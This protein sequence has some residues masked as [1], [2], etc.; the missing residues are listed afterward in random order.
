MTDASTPDSPT[1]AP[2]AYRF[3]FRL[4]INADD[5]GLSR[6]VNRGMM[7]LAD[8]GVVTS[9]S[10]LPHGPAF[11]ADAAELQ[12]RPDVST[13]LH[14]SLGPAGGMDSSG[15]IL[16]AL[17]ARDVSRLTAIFEDQLDALEQAI[18]RSITHVDSHL[19][20]HA[21]P[22]LRTALQGICDARN[23]PLRLPH[24]EVAAPSVKARMLRALF[25]GSDPDVAFFGIDLMG[26]IDRDRVEQT[27]EHIRQKGFTRAVW[28]V[29][30]GHVSDDHPDW[31]D[32]RSKR[33]QEFSAL[34]D[35]APWLQTAAHVVN[36]T[37][38]SD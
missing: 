3:P 29:H 21:V 10:A 13:G 15:H 38:L 12:R 16:P 30:P 22:A 25:S 17:K 33:E 24:E 11:A 31:D 23:L 9:V 28:M 4:C 35:L 19:H 36:R 26:R 34:R 27:F 37:A 18:G 32:Y 20:V 1:E 7:E 2:A 14:A 8:L 5:F 6:G